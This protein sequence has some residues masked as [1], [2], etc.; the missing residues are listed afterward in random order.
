MSTSRDDFG[1]AIRSALLRKGV[2][3]RFSLISFIFFALIIFFLDVY[4]IGLMKPIRSFV[5]DGIYRVSMIASFPSRFLPNLTGNITNLF[6]IKNEN[7]RL[8]NELE[9]YK[10]KEFKV[11]Y[12]INQN[13]VLKQF[14]DNE[15][16]AFALDTNIIVSKV[17]LDKD[18]PYLQSIIINKGSKAGVLKGMPVL[19][20]NY[21]IGRVVE[22]NYLSSRVL[23]INDLN[24]RI[25][26]TLDKDGT[27]AILKGNGGNQPVLE[28]LPEEYILKADINIFTSGK[29]QI[30]TPGTPVGKTNKQGTVTLYSNSTQLSFVKI[31]LTKQN[32]ESF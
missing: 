17:L 10:N 31:D 15:S 32:K 25:P 19:D 11:E 3:Q 26:V 14:L 24:S 23:L 6:E 9:V 8:R 20:N 7:I 5:N 18:S 28:Y 12:L 1:I 4:N 13:K 27:Q 22:T 2:A 16:E 29:D 21:L 30:F